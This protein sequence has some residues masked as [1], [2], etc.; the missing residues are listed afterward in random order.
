M[1][2]VANFMQAGDADA[3]ATEYRTAIRLARPLVQRSD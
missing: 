1:E 3:A 2:R